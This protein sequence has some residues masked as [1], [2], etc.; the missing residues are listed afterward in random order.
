MIPI[1]YNNRIYEVE[2]IRKFGKIS[3]WH[4]KSEIDFFNSEENLIKFIT[5]HPSYPIIGMHAFRN[6]QAVPELTESGINCNYY[7]QTTLQKTYD[8]FVKDRG[9]LHGAHALLCYLQ[10]EHPTQKKKREEITFSMF[11]DFQTKP[12]TLIS[13]NQ[14]EEFANNQL[15]IQPSEFHNIFKNSNIL[16]R[17]PFEEFEGDL[18]EFI[19]EFKLDKGYEIVNEFMKHHNI[20]FLILHNSY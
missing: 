6:F 17:K 19:E 18:Y 16:R 11:P 7:D 1:H 13:L 12:T 20:Y 3:S 15:N 14:L 10:S 4:I 8:Q 9:Y 5:K 2:P